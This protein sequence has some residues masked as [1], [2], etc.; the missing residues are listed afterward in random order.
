MGWLRLK[1]GYVAQQIQHYV[2]TQLQ[3]NGPD[4]LDE[5]LGRLSKKPGVKASIVIDRASGAILKTNGQIDALLTA[6][7][8]NASTAASFSSE[9]TISEESQAK[10]IEEFAQM[11]WNYVNSSGQ[12]VQEVDGEVR[13]D[14]TGRELLPCLQRGKGLMDSRIGRVETA[15]ITHQETRNRHCP[16]SKIPTNG[17][18]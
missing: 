4:A 16:G 3:S 17:Y 10:G 14:R 1:N 12:L 6:K 18:P 2:L 13:V 15:P 7:T 5:K 9:E 8:R 11:I